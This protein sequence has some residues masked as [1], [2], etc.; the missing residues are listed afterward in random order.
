MA[1][2]E[3]VIEHFH[4]F[5]K[6]PKGAGEHKSVLFFETDSI[7][8]AASKLEKVLNEWDTGSEQF[9]N[10]FPGCVGIELDMIDNGK[11]IPIEA[12]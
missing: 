7:V 2:F 10:L 1:R 4:Q 9:E 5:D 6:F 3:I 8:Q 11:R 12:H